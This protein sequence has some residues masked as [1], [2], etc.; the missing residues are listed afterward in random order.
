MLLTVDTVSDSIMK[1]DRNPALPM[2]IDELFDDPLVPGLTVHVAVVVVDTSGN[3]HMTGLTMAAAAPIDD[4]GDDPGSHLPTIADLNVEWVSAGSRILV[5]WVQ[6][7]IR[8]FNHSR[9]T[10]QTNSSIM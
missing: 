5:S 8:R 2:V 1:L 4:L 3:A 10:S 6:Q 7:V 9:Y